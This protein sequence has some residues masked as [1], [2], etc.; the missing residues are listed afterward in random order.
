MENTLRVFRRIPLHIILI[1][2]IAIWL[3]PTLALLVSSFRPAQ[4]SRPVVGGWPSKTHKNSRL[5]YTGSR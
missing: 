1:L 5:N 3:I 2:I 4:R